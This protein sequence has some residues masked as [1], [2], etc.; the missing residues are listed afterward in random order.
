MK[1]P[2]HRTDWVGPGP[3]KITPGPS[4]SDP[5]EL[6]ITDLARFPIVVKFGEL[7]YLLVQSSLG[8]LSLQKYP[9]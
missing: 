2:G 1:E 8:R 6:D 9:L 5:I 4:E 7:K 3:V